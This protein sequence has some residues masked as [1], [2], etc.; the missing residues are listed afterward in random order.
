METTISGAP[1][2]VS[3]EEGSDMT[4]LDSDDTGYRRYEALRDRLFGIV[5]LSAVRAGRL[6]LYSGPT[7]ENGT[8][9]ITVK[10]HFFGVWV[11][12]YEIWLYVADMEAMM[13]GEGQK[14]A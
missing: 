8:A 10:A 9:K 4:P 3:A 5:L 2:T 13:H 11:T 12:I 6:R 1:A 14:I 7:E